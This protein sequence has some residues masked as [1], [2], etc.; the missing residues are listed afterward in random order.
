MSRN[1]YEIE[2]RKALREEIESHY[3][4]EV[5]DSS[6]FFAQ[7]TKGYP[8]NGSKIDWSQIPGSI[9]RVEENKSLQVKQFIRFFNEVIQKFN[10]SG[11]VVYIGDNATDFALVGSLE[12][13][14]GV[15]S[16]LLT[17]PQHHYFVGPD[18]SWCICFT[19]E[20]D[21]GFGFRPPSTNHIPSPTN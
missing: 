3:I 13:M 5:G 16:E 14:M 21:M 18:S 4:K 10:L 1:F 9:E 17:I 7:L 15:V 12:C 6:P 19:M 11:N 20:G 8:A 2:L